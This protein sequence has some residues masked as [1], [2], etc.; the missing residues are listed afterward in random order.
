MGR[1]PRARAR[2]RRRTTT[3]STTP[4]LDHT[5][6]VA[7][8]LD[9][10]V[11]PGADRHDPGAGVPGAGAGH[12]PGLRRPRR[13]HRPAVLR[14]GPGEGPLVGALLPRHGPGRS[15]GRDGGGPGRRRGSPP[16]CTGSRCSCTATRGR[17]RPTSPASTSPPAGASSSRRPADR[18]VPRTERTVAHDRL[19]GAGRRPG[20]SSSWAAG[21]PVRRPRSPARTRGCPS[22][23]SR[24]AGA[25]GPRPGE[26]LHPGVEVVLRELGAADAAAGRL[27]PARRALG[28]S[29]AAR[30]ASTPSAGTRPGPG[31]ATRRRGT[32]STRC[33]WTAPRPPAPT[34]GGAAGRWT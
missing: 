16:R 10:A 20:T 25:R 12:G 31:T 11:H 27:G 8:S 23:C 28:A 18:P 33:C 15:R 4:R 13:G 32:S 6:Y 17:T 29:G 19:T 5:D 3:S 7:N 26:T 1:R 22:S 30:R 9:G 21:P 2:A 14:G 34:S 24:R